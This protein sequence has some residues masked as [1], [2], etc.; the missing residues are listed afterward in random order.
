MM[1]LYA[2]LSILLTLTC[3]GFGQT[4]TTAPARTSVE[5]DGYAARVNNRVITR[6]E[7]MEALAPVLPEL[8]RAYQGDQLKEEI[9]KAFIQVRQDLVERALIM[10]AF[11]A[12]G[13]Q[14]PDQMVNDEIKR[15][16]NSRF[17]GDK[18]LF[19]QV[20][21]DKKMTRAEYMDKIREK[22]AVS[23]MTSD[24]ISLR[25]RVTPE[26]V[27]QAYQNDR[28]SYL[29]PEKIK[30][31]LIVL[32]KGETTVDQTVKKKE[33]ERIREQLLQ[34][35][36]FAETAKTVSEGSRA[37]SGGSFPWMQ[38]KDARIE[39]QD[40]LST[41]PVGEISDVIE[42]ETQLY[43]VKIEARQQS[44][45]TPFEEVRREIQNRLEAEERKRLHDRWIARLMED[46]YV[47]IYD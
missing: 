45:Y 38:P 20:L 26:Q 24:N 32:N 13:G 40:A 37:D 19:E 21:A 3:T 12:T 29:I 10:E 9:D 46:N 27:L 17:K 16:I 15:T 28:E 47:V 36:N 11:K 35:A 4:N 44:T 1:K 22:I 30:Y 43:I 39:L 25:A 14:I 33:A 23:W 31:S 34:G 8:Y 2:F 18:T 7:V 6:S 41:L 42:T 5:I